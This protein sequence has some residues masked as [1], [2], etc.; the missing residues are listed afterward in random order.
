VQANAVLCLQ[1]LKVA[2][3]VAL[4]DLDAVRD[5]DGEEG[6]EEPAEHGGWD[7]MEM[8]TRRMWTLACTGGRGTRPRAWTPRN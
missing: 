4:L 3:T 2:V 5:G 7:E 6:E 1:V 8:V